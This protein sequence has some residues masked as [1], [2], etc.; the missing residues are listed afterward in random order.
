MKDANAR[1]FLKWAGGKEQLLPRFEKMWPSH[2][3]RYVEPFLGSGAVFFHLSGRIREAHLND[4]NNH[5]VELY[6]DV[7]DRLPHLVRRLRRLAGPEAN[8]K[9]VFYRRREEYNRMV[10]A[11]ACTARSALFL[12]LN[13]TCFNGL[14]RVNS[15]GRFNVPFGRYANPR[16]LDEERLRR[17][18]EALRKARTIQALPF[19]DFLLD[20]C[21]AGDLVYLDPPYAPV[22]ATADFT[23]YSRCAFTSDDQLRLAHV[24]AVLH[25]RGVRWLLSNSC[26]PFTRQTFV[27]DL[28]GRIGLPRRRP[29]VHRIPARRAINSRADRRGEVLEYAIKNF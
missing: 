12:Y 16:I 25:R 20:T 1:P 21:M 3:D 6:M 5:L 15:R 19:D 23:T 10:D 2:I 29:Y 7:R 8:S 22:S 4:V 27:T 14:Y 26:T 18:G 17:A 24:L 13:R 28:F 11:P 9:E